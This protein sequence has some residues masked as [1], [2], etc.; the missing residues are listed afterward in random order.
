MT[1]LVSTPLIPISQ[2]MGSH[3]GSQGIIYAQM[4]WEDGWDVTANISGQHYISDFNRFGSMF[5]YHG[6][7]WAGSIN[8]FGGLKA[9]PYIHNFVNF[10]KFKGP[11]Y[12]LWI[13]MPDYYGMMID[14]MERPSSHGKV[15]PEWCGVDWVNLKRLCETAT[16]VEPLRRKKVVAGD[17]H[18]ICMYRPTWDVNAVQYKTLYGALKMGLEQF[19]SFRRPINELEEI[20]FYFGNIDVRHHLCRQPDPIEAARDLAVRYYDAVAA[21]D[22]RGPKRVYELLPPENERRSLPK[23]GYHDGTPFFGERARRNECR[24]AFRDKLL[25][26]EK[27]VGGVEVV[28]WVDKYLII[29]QDGELDFKSM[30]VPHSVHLSR[31]SYPH[32]QGWNWNHLEDPKKSGL[33][34]FI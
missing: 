25:E 13:D 24:L 6:N 1:S 21:M 12:S 32:W 20:E 19:V 2:K 14:L 34:S 3:R 16:R 10:S 8:L 31:A 18:T 33:D 4:L 28:L 23:T 5:V 9:F 27:K 26:C 17:S 7:D 22:F 15:N 29:N 30:E 11:A